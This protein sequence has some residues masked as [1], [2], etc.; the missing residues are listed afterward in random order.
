MY[1]LYFMAPIKAL[2]KLT[3]VSNLW[4]VAATT[5]LRCQNLALNP[6]NIFIFFEFY[7]WNSTYSLS[8]LR[9]LLKIALL[10]HVG[11]PRSHSAE[12]ELVY[13]SVD[14][15]LIKTTVLFSSSRPNTHLTRLNE[16]RDKLNMTAALSV[17]LNYAPSKHWHYGHLRSDQV[18][19]SNNS[20]QI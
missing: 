19:Q 10:C 12:H 18:Q 1:L 17:R 5:A 20:R 6:S 14:E 8:P 4:F 2:S 13:F 15:S 11:S 16:H 3:T 9:F 7:S